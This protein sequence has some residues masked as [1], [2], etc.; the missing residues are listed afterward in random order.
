M[1]DASALAKFV[2]KEPSWKNLKKY[3]RDSVSVDHVF[4]EVANSIWKTYRR[5]FITLEDAKR[6]YEALKLLVENVIEIVDEREFM[7]RAFKIALKNNIT[8]YD[9]LY[10]ALSQEKELTLLTSNHLQAKTAE[11]LGI[12]VIKPE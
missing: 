7:D 2:L 11:K 5:G 12:Q 8:I 4:K 9:A 10:I 1:I 3:L 6:K